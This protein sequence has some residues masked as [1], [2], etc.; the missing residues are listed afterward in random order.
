MFQDIFIVCF[1][2]VNRQSLKAVIRKWVPE[3]RHHCKTAQ[4]LLVGTK[5]DL[6][7]DKA[8]LEDMANAK[9]RGETVK[10]PVGS[11]EVILPS[12]KKIGFRFE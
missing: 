4:I 6:Y 3:I 5:L 1:S 9:A 11:K 7:E 2:L 8:V 10:D 12:I